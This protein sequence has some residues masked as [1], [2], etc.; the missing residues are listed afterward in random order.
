VSA[1]CACL[2]ASVAL[3]LGACGGEERAVAPAPAAPADALPQPRLEGVDPDVVAAIE[4]AVAAVRAAPSA[5]S[6]GRLGNRYFAHDFMAEAA[7]CFARAEELDPERVA[8][9]YRRG[10]CS[11]DDD[12]AE[13]AVHLARALERLD[14]HAPAHENYARVLMRLGRGDEAGPHFVRASELDPRAPQAETGLGQLALQRGDFQAARRHLETALGR[15]ERHGEAHVAL[16]QALLALGDAHGAQQHAARSRTLPQASR[17]EDV[18]ANPSVEPAGARARTRF[19]RQLERQDRPHEAAEQYRIA[20]RSNPDYY[21]ARASLAA[22]LAR[23][24][25]RDEAVELLRQG[26]QRNPTGEQVKQDLARLL[27]T[28]TLEPAGEE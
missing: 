13:A 17:R 3:V 2:A 10:L 5:E 8:W 12:P 16:A 25:K 4:A 19:G 14:D 26:E 22:L 20:L 28:G 23:Q 15:D 1:H 24:G 7:R 11:I 27:E 6:W 9:T 21:F 18:Y